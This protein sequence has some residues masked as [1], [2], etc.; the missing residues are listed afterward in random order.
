MKSL[1][2]AFKAAWVASCPDFQDHVGYGPTRATL[3]NP[4]LAT[5]WVAQRFACAAFTVEMPFKDNNDLPDPVA[6]WSGARSMKFGAGVLQPI[7]AL[8]AQLRA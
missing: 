8:L 7:L 6:G 2:D 4:T 1:Q 5:N 3:A